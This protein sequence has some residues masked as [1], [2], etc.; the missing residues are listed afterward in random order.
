M[1]KVLV[2][3]DLHA[4]AV[5][6]DYFEFI[7]SIR[8]KHRTDQTVF[9]GDVID[10]HV[11]SYHKSNPESPDA[12]REYELAFETVKKWYK[13]FPNAYV[14]IGNHD[15][16]VHRLAADAGIPA[17]Y[18]KEYKELYKTKNWEWVHNVELDG[19]YYYHGTGAASA[20]PA[21][22]AAR[23]RNQ[24]VVMGHHHT[25]AAI[26]WLSGPNNHRIFGMSV[27]CGVDNTHLSMLYSEHYLVKPMLSC[28][29]VHNGHPI[30]EV[31]PV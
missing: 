9:I 27:G 2:I 3:G 6:E 11:I 4:P 19:V 29:V 24:S 14:T 13:A 23:T 30:L 10:H 22:N 18:L 7:R 8:R 17:M 28:G 16:R 12:I 1:S 31:M 20:Y 25:K 15:N 5:H 21:F 26:N